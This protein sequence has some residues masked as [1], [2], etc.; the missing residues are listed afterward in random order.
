MN[1]NQA[2]NCPEFP[3][4][5]VSSGKCVGLTNKPLISHYILKQSEQCD[6]NTK[7]NIVMAFVSMDNNMRVMEVLKVFCNMVGSF[8]NR[9]E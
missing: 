6:L 1:T 2:Y 7:T 3:V 4:S 9:F 8:K 5:L